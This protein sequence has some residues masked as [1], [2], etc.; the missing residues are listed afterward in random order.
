MNT[1]NNNNNK[2]IALTD[3]SWS[4]KLLSYSA[5][6]RPG[7][8]RNINLLMGA[9]FFLLITVYLL[10]PVKEMLILVQ[11]NAELRSYIVGFQ[12]IILIVL[13]PI[14]GYFSRHLDSKKFMV[15]IA[16]FFAAN[17]FVF[18]LLSIAGHNAAIPFFIWLGAFGVLMLSQFWAYASHIYIHYIQSI[19]MRT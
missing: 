8:G 12:V 6:I 2:T 1:E 10:K 4:E 16:F 14:Y 11:G 17:L 5:Q 18:Y 3:L 13:L 7:E 19:Y 15:A 9:L